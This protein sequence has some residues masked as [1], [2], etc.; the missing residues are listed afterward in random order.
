[1][2]IHRGS[3]ITASIIYLAAGAFSAA[4]MQRLAESGISSATLKKTGTAASLASVAKM[5][6]SWRKFNI[7]G[8]AAQPSKT[9]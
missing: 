1:M 9:P 7:S 3:E 2:T 4:E 6:I 8:E 5:K